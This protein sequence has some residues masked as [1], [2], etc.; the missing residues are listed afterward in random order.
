VTVLSTI[1]ERNFVRKDRDP[2]EGAGRPKVLWINCRLLHPLIGGDRLRTF[3]MLRE[4]KK[5]WDITYACPITPGDSDQ[6]LEDAESYC[7]R[8]VA[9]RH[10]F[11]GRGTAQF[12]RGVLWNCLFGNLPFAAKKYLSPELRRWLRAQTEAASFNLIVCDYL[13]SFIHILTLGKPLA[14]PV[15]VFQ[16][17]VESLI[18]QRHAETATNPLKRW[19][20][21]RE[22]KLTEKMED[23]CGLA[24]AGQVTVSPEETLHF[25]QQ[26]GMS[27]VLGDVPT[28]VDSNY[29]APSAGFE[30]H[31]I[32]FLGSM[33]WEANA[34]AVRRFLQESYPQIK[35]HFPQAR[36]LIIGR[37]PPA[38]LVDIAMQDPSIEVTGTVPDVRPYLYRASIMV[39]P[40]S[41]GGGTRV[42]VFEAMAAGLAVVSTPVGV[43]GLRVEHGRHA[44]IAELGP[45]FSDAV[46]SLMSDL[47][48]RNAIARE[49]RSW[50]E[51][52]FSWSSAASR[53]HDLAMPLIRRRLR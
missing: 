27:N 4:L 11:P 17:N 18:W 30:P 47:P 39:L 53:F 42:K 36:F 35:A 12:A 16:H 31:T 33:D 13:V 20:Y 14:T 23:V 40:L 15:I 43:E 49:A 7:D 44:L 25:S 52:S 24:A 48:R 41:V 37:N 8:V 9:F 6:A 34:I 22:R 26:R 19:I 2:L 3:H 21:R 50:V 51:T 5:N 29:F 38:D 45:S 32:A 46:L 28:G 10:D 1:I